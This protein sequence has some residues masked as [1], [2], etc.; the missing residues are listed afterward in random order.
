MPYI[1]ST[2]FGKIIVDEVEY[3]Q[4][5]I[6]GDKVL[7]REY[8]KLKD[9]FGTSHR[10]GSWEIE[11]LLK[12]DPEMIVFGIGQ[13]GMMSVTEEDLVAFKDK[14]VLVNLTPEAIE[15]Y[16]INVKNGKRV[17]ALIHTTC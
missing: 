1:N 15:L 14:E 5:L 12:G 9:T 16:N 17:N 13:D 6:I 10:I 2:S 3:I 4:I 8:Q 7:E 11:E